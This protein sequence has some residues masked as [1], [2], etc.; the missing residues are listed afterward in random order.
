MPR[1]VIIGAGLTGLSAAYHLEKNNFFDFAIYEKE[2]QPGGLMRSK[3]LDEWTFD[4]TG[5][6]LHISDPGFADFINDISGIQN[7]NHIQRNAAIYAHNTHV[8]YPFQM[9]LFGL[10]TD[11]IYE[12]LNGYI[13]RTATR[14]TPKTF[15]EWVLKHF[16]KGFGDHFFFPYNNKLLVYSIKK[17]HHSWTGRFVPQTSFYNILK[18]ALEKNPHEKIGYNS[19]FYYPKTGGIG[20]FINNLATKITTPIQTNHHVVAIDQNKKKIFFSD[21]KTASYEILITTA[22]LDYTLKTLASSSMLPL[23]NVAQNL[24]CNAVVNF[25][26]GF[27][28]HDIGPYHWVYFPEKHYQFY[29]I[30]FWHNINKSLAAPE[31][32]SI[33]GELSYQPKKHSRISIQKKVDISI[34]QTLNVLGLTNNDIKVALTLDLANA[35]V[36]YDLWREKNISK[37]LTTLENMH[38]YSTGRFGA[39]KYSSMQEAYSDGKNAASYAIASKSTQKNQQPTLIEYSL[40]FKHANTKEHSLSSNN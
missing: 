36:T 2:S 19:F 1:V 17:I 33:Y 29:R 25:N 27:N 15:Y 7:F 22:P 39:W 35:Y 28:V 40:K 34:A 21:G 30:G 37:L 11:I 10:P 3:H 32:S 38:I 4:Y 24:W 12:C 16:G 14:A 13:K 20:S 18:G 8:G 26:L 5:H 9:N 23:S 31:C 6:Y